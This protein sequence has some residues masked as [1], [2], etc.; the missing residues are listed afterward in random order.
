MFSTIS[1]LSSEGALLQNQKISHWANQ[2]KLKAT[3]LLQNAFL[4]AL[5]ISVTYMLLLLQIK[6]YMYKVMS[7]NSVVG[8][9]TGCGMD[10]WRIG[11]RVP[12]SSRIFSSPRVPGFGVH[13]A[14]YPMGTGGKF[15]GGKAA[16]AW[17]WPLTSKCRGQEN[18]DLYIHSPIRL[19]SIVLK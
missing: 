6:L 8:I 12:L 19:H 5:R 10:D 2:Q 14:S 3:P 1:R 11:V 7:R 17:S 13:P 16:G 18:V 15:P 9:A 4:V